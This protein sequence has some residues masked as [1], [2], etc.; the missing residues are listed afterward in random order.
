MVL[1]HA[2]IDDLPILLEFE[3]GVLDAERLMDTTLKREDTYYYD[4]PYLI[5]EPTVALLVAEIN[6]VIVACGYAKIIQ[7]R[8]CFT[9]NRFSYLGFMYTK[10]AFRGN[11]I[12]KQIIDYLCDW[13]I[14][15]GIY[16]V[17]L[18]VYPSNT[19][20]IQAYKK[21]GMDATMVTMRVGLKDKIKKDN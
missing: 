20:A 9:F 10:E 3:Q 11:G 17:R 13:S 6:G 21:V 16:E 7:A 4:L 12:N 2:T 1:R 8:D 14:H 5:N 15:R 19:A 18:E